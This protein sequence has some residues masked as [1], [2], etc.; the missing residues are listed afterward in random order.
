MRVTE[1]D[2]S[3]L[4]LMPSAKHWWVYTHHI[5]RQN[6]WLPSASMKLM[7]IWLS[8]MQITWGFAIQLI[9]YIQRHIYY[10]SN[11]IS[12]CH[13]WFA[14]LTAGSGWRNH[15]MNSLI[16]SVAQNREITAHSAPCFCI[17]IK[18]AAWY[19]FLKCSIHLL[20]FCICKSI[21]LTKYMFVECLLI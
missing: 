20:L 10:M 16:L 3:E 6:L 15:C 2:S 17:R 14:A 12:M 19:N 4:I 21:S 1:F 18:L 11:P 9:C 13:K 8:A 7:V 5:N